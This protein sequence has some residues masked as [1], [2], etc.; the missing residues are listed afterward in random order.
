MARADDLAAYLDE[1]PFG[2][3][4]AG[5]PPDRATPRRETPPPAVPPSRD[6]QIIADVKEIFGAKIVKNHR[7]RR[8]SRRR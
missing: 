1:D 2:E 8:K 5:T 4:G 3:R 6:A 7:H